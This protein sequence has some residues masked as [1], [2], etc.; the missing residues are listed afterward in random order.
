MDY[1]N[2]QMLERIFNEKQAIPLLH[3]ELLD[4]E[5]IVRLIEQS[6]LD[7]GFALDLLAQMMLHKRATVATLVGLLK[8][9]FEKKL[10]PYQ[11]CADA[12]Q[13]AAEVDLIDYDIETQKF[14][15]RFDASAAVHDLIRQ[16]QTLPPMIVPPKPLRTFGSN[17]GSGY[18]TI[19][20]DSLLLQDNHH[21]GDICTDSLQKFNQIPLSIN[22]DVVRKIRNE[23]QH[24]DKAKP[25]ENWNE[26]QERRKAFERYEKDSLFTIALMVEMGNRFYLTHK[27]DKR[28]RTYAQGYHINPQGNCWN[29]A[30]IELADPE[31]IEG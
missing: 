5:Y 1:E 4:S 21:G 27:V 15:L 22:T 2:Q 19:R 16:Y 28:G 13:R 7:Q 26:F 6:Q 17:R 3:K 29:K 14:I 20:T 11:A 18:L 24:L 30:C 23:W 25:G 31:L 9:H 10:N 12:L 8:Y